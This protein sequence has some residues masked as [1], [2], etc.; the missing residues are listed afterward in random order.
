MSIAPLRPVDLGA[1]SIDTLVY[2]Q[3]LFA[4][5]AGGTPASGWPSEA[6]TERWRH[7]AIVQEVGAILASG[8]HYHPDGVLLTCAQVTFAAELADMPGLG[9]NPVL[10]KA[11]ERGAE[12]AGRHAPS[13]LLPWAHNGA[14]QPVR[15]IAVGGGYGSIA[16]SGYYG[17]GHGTLR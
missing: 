8:P 3:Q 6:T 13:A 12:V 1:P 7:M 4:I 5:E 9:L 2:T 16:V 10:A 11:L 17:T 15:V 14:T